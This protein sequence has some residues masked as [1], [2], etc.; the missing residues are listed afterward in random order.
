MKALILL[1]II[2]FAVPENTLHAQ[3]KE[4]YSKRELKKIRR[5]KRWTYAII[6][7]RFEDKIENS[8]V[9]ENWASEDDK[10]PKAENEE[11]YK[12]RKEGFLKDSK[13]PPK[14]T[15]KETIKNDIQNISLANY[16]DYKGR[17]ANIGIARKIIAP[18]ANISMIINTCSSSQYGMYIRT[19]KPIIR[20]TSKKE[21][22]VK[23]E[24]S[25]IEHKTNTDL[26]SGSRVE[27]DDKNGNPMENLQCT[28]DLI[29]Y[30]DYVKKEVYY[31][32]IYEKD[33]LENCA[34]KKP[35]KFF[36]KK[37]NKITR[38]V[39]HFTTF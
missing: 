17:G 1:L 2:L 34:K 30:R 28:N 16:E 12:S 31:F 10:P 24:F 8:I 22:S 11:E 21:V 14:S 7:T 29:V 35:I 38:K 27:V 37:Y 39:L 18:D 19:K 4:K 36:K 32:G 13:I 15:L 5:F 9:L 26:F 20:D 25:R 23:I 33:Q 3:Q 6:N